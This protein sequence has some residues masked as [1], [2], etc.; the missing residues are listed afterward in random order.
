M[1]PIHTHGIKKTYP[2]SSYT[3]RAESL[4]PYHMF[5]LYFVESTVEPVYKDMLRTNNLIREVEASTW[6]PSHKDTTVLKIALSY[7]VEA[8]V[9]R[10]ASS[11]LIN[12]KRSKSL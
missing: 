6:K 9:S 12:C 11:I 3:L 10:S 7:L 5:I 2:N 4:S 1:K 8:L